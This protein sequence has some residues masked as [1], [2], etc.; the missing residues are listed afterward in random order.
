MSAALFTRYNALVADRLRVDFDKLQE[1]TEE[2]I[3]SSASAA[4]SPRT[5]EP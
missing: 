5:P 3:A 2:F 1:L 4:N